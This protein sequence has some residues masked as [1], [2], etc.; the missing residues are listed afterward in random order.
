MPTSSPM[1][2]LDLS[3]LHTAIYFSVCSASVIHSRFQWHPEFRV[4]WMSRLFS[5][6]VSSIVSNSIP[7]FTRAYYG[8]TWRNTHIGVAT[9][10]VAFPAPLPMASW[11]SR[12]LNVASFE[13]VAITEAA[14]LGVGFHNFLS[15][16]ISRFNCAKYGVLWWRK[17]WNL[18][19]S[20]FVTACL[21]VSLESSY[22]LK[23]TR[24]NFG[25]LLTASLEIA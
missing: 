6:W 7:R 14:T 11:G 13:D 1:A 24:A 8:N 20:V 25:V 21:L 23:I 22:T 4:C 18:S 2:F 19:A 17:E 12:A 15:N 10:V 9:L 16:G 5:V 3:M